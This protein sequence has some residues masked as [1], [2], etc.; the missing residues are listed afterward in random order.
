MG[1]GENNT[2]KRVL[3]KD[4]VAA[5]LG[6]NPN[7]EDA[8]RVLASGK[9]HIAQKIIDLANENKLPIYREERLAHQLQ[10]LEIG[11]TIPPELYHIVAEILVFIGGIDQNYSKH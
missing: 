11:E 3:H 1:A 2:Q 5:A 7:T 10:N 9:G 4:K 8:P 6:F